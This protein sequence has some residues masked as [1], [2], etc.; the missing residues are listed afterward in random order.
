MSRNLDESSFS[1]AGRSVKV[2][3]EKGSAMFTMP[4]QQEE[5]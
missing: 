4:G 1:A 3:L 5:R 2:S